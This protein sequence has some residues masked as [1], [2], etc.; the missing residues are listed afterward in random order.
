MVAPIT[1][2]VDQETI[3]PNATRPWVYTEYDYRSRW[4]QKSP[5]DQPL[6]F[7]HRYGRV[8]TDSGAYES[9]IIGATGGFIPGSLDNRA[10]IVAYDRYKNSL[11]DRAQ[12]AVSL[13][14]GEQSLKMITAR[15]LQ[16]SKFTK[17]LK[18]GHLGDAWKILKAPGNPPRR[19]GTGKSWA[20]NYLEFHF[21]WAPLVADIYSAVN[22]LQAPFNSGTAKGSSTIFTHTEQVLPLGQYSPS[23]WIDYYS[24]VRYQS[25]VRISNP[26]LWLANQL[27]L[28]NPATWVYEKIPFSFVADWFFNVGQF[29]ELGTDMMGLTLVNPFTTFFNRGNVV[30]LWRDYGWRAEVNYGYMSRSLGI[31]Q[32]AFGLRPFKLWGWRRAA[33]AASLL[34]QQT[35]RR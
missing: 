18:K 15:L 1:G 25:E 33:A 27:G 29:L 19:V 7:H 23:R 16:L 32:P 4:R 12:A 20:N 34:I 9:A 5:I 21:G 22:V 24:T 13:L 6:A 14:E 30:T 26:N 2:P 10:A 31:T 8:I 3:V 17:A 11:S 28:I 35:G